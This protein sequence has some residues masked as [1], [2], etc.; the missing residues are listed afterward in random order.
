MAKLVGMLKG[1][2][3]LAAKEKRRIA[4]WIGIGCP[5]L[6]EE[7]GRISNG[8]QNL[9]GNWQTGGFNLAERLEAALPELDG[10][11]TRVVMHNDAVV[12]GLSE[13]P[14]QQD[15]TGWGVVT[16]GTGLGNAHFTNRGR[17]GGGRA[18]P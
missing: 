3:A 7:D 16:I 18:E 9:P 2:A 6:I 17:R 1:L 11:P 13:A 4:P 5:G 15:L 14:F 8:A 10:A 12:Q